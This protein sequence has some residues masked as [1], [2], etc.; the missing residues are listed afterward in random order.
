MYIYI[1]WIRI[2][3]LTAPVQSHKVG[4]KQCSDF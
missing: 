2:W 3:R 1:Y 4:S